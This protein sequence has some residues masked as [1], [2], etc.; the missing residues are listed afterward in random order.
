M[1]LHVLLCI[2]FLPVLGFTK[3]NLIPYELIKLLLEEHPWVFCFVNLVDFDFLRQSFSGFQLLR[4]MIAGIATIVVHLWSLMCWSFFL[5]V[6]YVALCYSSRPLLFTHM[7]SLPKKQWSCFCEGL[8]D[9]FEVM[10]HPRWTSDG[11]CMSRAAILF[12]PCLLL[13]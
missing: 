2:F 7:S 10:Y 1:T 11:D 13:I 4:A 6:S 12:P 9:V 5:L 3:E 8:L